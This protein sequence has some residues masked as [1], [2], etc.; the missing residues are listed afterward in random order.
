MEYALPSSRR[1]HWSDRKNR[2]LMERHGIGF[3]DV[4]SAIE[5]GGFL[6]MRRHPDTRPYGHQLQLL[7]EIDGYV[8]VVP[9]VVHDDGLFLKTLYPSRKATAA[10]LGR[11]SN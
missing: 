11:G 10:Y 7:V 1:L 4:V 5:N 8:F 6:D 3:S 9:C 2:E